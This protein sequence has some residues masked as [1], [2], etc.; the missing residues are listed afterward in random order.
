VSRSLDPDDPQ[1]A[2]FEREESM[3]TG[4]PQGR[5]DTEYRTRAA[6]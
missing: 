2:H 5:S 6:E 1:S 4:R 3:G